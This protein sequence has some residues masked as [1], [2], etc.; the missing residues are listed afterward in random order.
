[1]NRASSPA[2]VTRDRWSVAGRMLAASVGGYA[3]TSLG[4]SVLAQLLT[5]FAGVLPAL[6]VLSTTLLSF[7]IYTVVVLWMFRARSALRM[8]LWLGICLGVLA[9]ASWLLR[10][11]PWVG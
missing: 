7:V 8:W 2:S 1:M 10:S 3:L 9:G 6:A 11:T 4:C 5:R